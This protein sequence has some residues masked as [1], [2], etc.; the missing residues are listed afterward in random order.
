MLQAP[1]LSSTPGLKH[2]FFTRQNGTSNGLYTSLNCGFGSSDIKASVQQNRVICADALGVT[3]N[4]LLTV[5]QE[6]T[7]DVVTVAAPWDDHGPPIADGMVT[8]TPGLAIGILTA[9]C[10]PVLFVDPEA[11]VIGAAHAGWKGAFGG[12]IEN[13]VQAMVQ[14][15]ARRR[16]ILVAVGPCIG[17]SSYEIGPEFKDR[18]IDKDPETEKFFT[19]SPKADHAFFDIGRYVFDLADAAGVRQV[20]RLLHDTYEEKDLFFSYRRSCHTKE[21]DYGRQ[22]SGIAWLP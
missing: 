22:L 6:H 1:T 19:P 20:E 4:D 18:F 7:A 3:V 8:A 10:T 9:D 5:H 17:A 2:G 11:G 21:P 15:G 12:I 14:I 13:T 16:Q